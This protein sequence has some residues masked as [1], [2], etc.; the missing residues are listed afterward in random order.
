M[1]RD[2]GHWLELTDRFHAAAI[3]GEG[4][5]GALQG[6]A[7]ATGSK[8]GELIC[9]APD[10]S[11]TLNIMTDTSPEL[12]EAFIAGNGG[13]PDV[14]PRVKAGM[15]APVL[16]VLAEADFITPE[17]HSRHPHYRSFARPFDIPYICLA[18][19]D[20][21][22][23]GLTGLA[24]TR[25]EKEGHIS[26][27][28]RR[29]FELFAP[30][31]RAAVRSHIALEGYG[32]ALLAGALEAVAI[33]AFVCD[34]TGRVRAQ[35]PSA[36]A[37][38]AKTRGLQ[39]RQGRLSAMNSAGAQ[40]L[41]D[42]ISLAASALGRGRLGPRNRTVIVRSSEGDTQPLVLDVIA[43][44]DHQFEFTFAPRVLVLVRGESADAGGQ[45]RAAI[46]RS[47]YGMTAAE[48]EIALQLFA[49]GSP[50]AIAEQRAVTVETVR[51]QIKSLLAKAGARRQVELVARLSQM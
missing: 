28:Q 42:A 34:E 17:E 40:A 35:T 36:E 3:D 25:T 21:K 27:E 13:D 26:P 39:L 33:P 46:L 11:V 6:L 24:V 43:L 10:R 47:V 50:E 38:L 12:L 5:Y 49:G 16:K 51:T 18:T 20:R 30:H 41:S 4:W 2:D 32:D 22:A 15:E 7:G 29:I 44:P 19:L 14:N 45:R 1:I 48:T 9:I 31:V 37:V 23:G 8:S